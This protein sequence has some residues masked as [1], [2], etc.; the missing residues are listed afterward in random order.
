VGST[1]TSVFGNSRLKAPKLEKNSRS[2]KWKEVAIFDNW[3]N[4]VMDI[5]EVG[6]LDPEDRSA[7][8]W[9]G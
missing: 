7:M 1:T 4:D 9:L 2:S 5:L 3:V 8:I 6:E